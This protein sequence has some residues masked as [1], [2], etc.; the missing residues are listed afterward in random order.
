MGP[1]IWSPEASD[2]LL[3][4]QASMQSCDLWC[5]LMM[6]CLGVPG[7][8]NLV[9]I[10]ARLKPYG[11]WSKTNIRSTAATQQAAGFS[12]TCVQIG[13]GDG[14]L[15]DP[16][17]N[18]TNSPQPLLNYFVECTFPS[19][20]SQGCWQHKGVH[21]CVHVHGF[22]TTVW[23]RPDSLTVES[24]LNALLQHL[25]P[26]ASLRLPSTLQGQPIL[27]LVV[28]HRSLLSGKHSEH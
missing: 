26:A 4:A 20:G 21:M 17:W 10:S 12:D 13:D 24:H 3:H 28:S 27:G 11:W 22:V 5:H 6:P 8:P 19:T 16:E 14:M 15:E 1:E 25:L 2:T 7:E 23:H 18:P 9:E